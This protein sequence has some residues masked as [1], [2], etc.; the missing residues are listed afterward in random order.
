MTR[1]FRRSKK[2]LKVECLSNNEDF[3]DGNRRF[4][5]IGN[6]CENTS[7]HLINEAIDEI[8][9]GEAN[10]VSGEKFFQDMRKK[11]DK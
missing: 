9:G 4:D 11:Y 2:S 8:D 7:G 10:A 6:V 5:G 1:Q 3:H